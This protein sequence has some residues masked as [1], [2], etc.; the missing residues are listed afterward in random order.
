[1]DINL[2]VECMAFVIMLHDARK[3]RAR[4]VSL[5]TLLALSLCILLSFGNLPRDTSRRYWKQMTVVISSVAAFACSWVVSKK[6]EANGQDDV[7]IPRL[8]RW[9]SRISIYL[10]TVVCSLLSLLVACDFSV[11][12]IFTKTCKFKVA[13]CTVQNYLH[14]FALLPQLML[15]R[16]QGFVCPAATRFLFIIG[17]KDIYEF[18]SDAYVSYLRYQ[19][20]LFDFRE[21]S[22]MSGDFVAACV[23][24][25]FLYLVMISKNKCLLVG[26]DALDLP[27]D[28]KVLNE[29][30]ADETP[31]AYA[32]TSCSSL[33]V[34]MKAHNM[35]K[36]S[37]FVG[38]V[39]LA[40]AGAYMQILDVYALV[41]SGLAYAALRWTGTARLDLAKMEMEEKCLV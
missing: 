14:A 35:K 36:I 30:S 37:V 38:T 25:D 11:T 4:L 22:F 26:D 16:H 17:V 2:H 21:V 15:C 32:K 13:L 31:L 18:T 29:A 3:G 9:T 7:T 23:L 33:S 28:E 20:G 12:T 39:T 40:I 10:L 1:M 41:F 19:K 6:S 5:Q 27:E 8:P 34:S 24:L